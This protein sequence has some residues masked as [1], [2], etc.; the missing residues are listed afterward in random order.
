MDIRDLVPRRSD[1]STFVVHLT[2][3][4]K[5]ESAKKRLKS[6][7]R[8]RRI[9]ARSM[10]GQAKSRLEKRKL[11]CDS[12]KCVCFTETPIEYTYLLLEAIE[13]RGVH[14]EPYGIAITKR[15]ARQKGVNPVWYLDIT[16]GHQWLTKPVNKLINKALTRGSFDNSPIAKLAPFIEQMGT[17]KNKKGVIE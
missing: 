15:V 12:Q 8:E 5:K 6:I 10:F 4:E 11:N 14:F 1:L 13:N 2:R 9:K 17:K 7:L 16:P 3:N